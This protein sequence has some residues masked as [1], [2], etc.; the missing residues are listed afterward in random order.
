MIVERPKPGNIQ[1][2][3]PWV[4][5]GRM[6]ELEF[7]AHARWQQPETSLLAGAKI[8]KET[9][10]RKSLFWL[11]VHE[12]IVAVRCDGKVWWRQD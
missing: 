6:K 12:E 7:D 2:L 8:L 3:Q 10:R 4:S 5:T 11:I 9:C 1:E